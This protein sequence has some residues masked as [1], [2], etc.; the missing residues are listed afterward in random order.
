MV[1][2]NDTSR[3]CGV[4]C[5]LSGRIPRNT[6]VDDNCVFLFSAREQPAAER[7]F[8]LGSAFASVCVNMCFVYVSVVVCVCVAVSCVCAFL[9]KLA[10]TALITSAVL[11]CVSVY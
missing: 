6:T 7:F 4:G 8:R 9:S 11:V 5:V 3:R 10:P 1:R 2:S